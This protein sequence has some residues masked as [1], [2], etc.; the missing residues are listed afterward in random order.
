MSH[1]IALRLQDERK[2]TTEATMKATAQKP[3]Q[4]KLAGLLATLCCG[5]MASTTTAR[6]ADVTFERLQNPEPQNWLMNHRTYD[7]QR[8]SP[9]DQ[10]NKGNIK[11]L[12]L[13]FAIALGGT[14]GNEDLEVTPLVDDGFMYVIDGWGVV[15]KIDVRSGKSG[16]IVWKM[17]P[18]Q[19]KLGRHRGVT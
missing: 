17:D 13:K 15:Y 9:L 14:S 3:Q 6:A 11:N 1:A 8:H 10:I 19:E 18:S 4:M 16:N 2:K 5:L 12:Q 7:S